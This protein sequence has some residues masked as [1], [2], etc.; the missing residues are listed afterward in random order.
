MA[1]IIKK[2][3]DEVDLSRNSEKF[4]KSTE[5]CEIRLSFNG[6]DIRFQAIDPKELK[7]II[8]FIHTLRVETDDE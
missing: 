2:R 7:K 4:I 6:C 3:D 8:G 5:K 1:V